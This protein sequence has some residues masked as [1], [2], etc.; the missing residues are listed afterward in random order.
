MMMLGHDWVCQ[1]V[2]VSA[3][4]FRD[5]PFDLGIHFHISWRRHLISS[6]HVCQLGTGSWLGRPLPAQRA[7]PGVSFLHLRGRCALHTA[8][9]GPESG[10]RDR[11]GGGVTDG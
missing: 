3:A 6:R 7:A 10:V 8:E 2:L 4:H 9:S 11:S 1:S 5:L